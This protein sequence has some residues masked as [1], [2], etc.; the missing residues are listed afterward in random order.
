M[1]SNPVSKHVWCERGAALI[2][3]LAVIV[4]LLMVGLLAPRAHD[5]PS[6]FTV[7][8]TGDESDLDFPEDIFDGSSDG[9]CDVDTATEDQCTLKA[10][11]QETNEN[12]NSPEQDQIIFDIPAASD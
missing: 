6:T 7:N 2:V 12:D 9:K 11:I 4:E 1:L 3:G 8:S 5:A 10:A